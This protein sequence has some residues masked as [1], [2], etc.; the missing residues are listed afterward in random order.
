LN[1]SL[2]S[3]NTAG[4]T[5]KV[6][7]N[8]VLLLGSTSGSMTGPQITKKVSFFY[9]KNVMIFAY[10]LMQDPTYEKVKLVMMLAPTICLLILAC[11]R[12]INIIENRRRDK[13][14]LRD[15]HVA[16]S[17]FLDLTDGENKEFRYQMYS[18]PQ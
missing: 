1:F 8:C 5:K 3:A 12:L 16:N 7:T 17:E 6:L 11:I 2:V 15:E 18:H 10:E 13:L 14:E 9:L 4:H